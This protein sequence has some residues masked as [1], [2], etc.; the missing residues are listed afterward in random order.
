MTGIILS[1]LEFLKE[2]IKEGNV[3]FI[4][5]AFIRRIYFKE[6][7]YGFKRDLSKEIEKPIS[8]V[9]TTIRVALENDRRKTNNS[10]IYFLFSYLWRSFSWPFQK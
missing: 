1:R 9:K 7:C 10:V 6:V 8:L 5:E 3:N 2:L 4:W